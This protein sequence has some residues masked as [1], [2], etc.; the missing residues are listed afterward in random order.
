M[1]DKE[2]REKIQRSMDRSLSGLPR[3]SFLTER[4]LNKAQ[5]EEGEKKVIK[6]QTGRLVLAVVLIVA[7]ATAAL[8]LGN[9]ETLKTYFE[10]VRGMESTGELARWSAEDKI[11]LARAM[12]EAGIVTED[13][14]RLQAALDEDKPLSQRG[15]AAD[16]LISQ[17][18]G[19]DYF[20]SYT[21][22]QLELLQAGLSPTDQTAYGQWSEDY[23]ARWSQKEKQPLTE[24]R[25]YL[26]TMNNLTE[27]GDFPRE[28][29]REVKVSGAWEEGEGLYAVT[30][31]IDKQTYRAAQRPGSLSLFDTHALEPEEGDT[32]SFRFWLDE[33]GAF[34]G[35]YDPNAPENRA[36]IT[37]R[38]AQV[39]AEKALSVRLGV[40][41]KTRQALPLRSSCGEGNEYVLEEG[42]FRAVCAF[43]WGE[44]EDP[45]YFVDIDAQTGRVI[46]A[47][48]WRE[49]QTM[50]EKEKAWL[51][52]IRALLRQAGVSDTLYNQEQVYFWRW[53]LEQKA[54]WSKTARPLIERYLAEHDEFTGYLEDLLAKRYSQSN[55]PNLI[56]LTQYAYGIPGEDAL[57]QEKAFEIAREAALQAGA[58][59]S[60]V[61]DSEGHNFYYD[62][63]DP[64]QPLWKVLVSTM[65]PADDPAHP[66]DPK[67][68]WGYFAVID[69]TTGELLKLQ[70]R[71]VNTPMRELV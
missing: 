24:S 59:Q 13:D 57:T 26:A 63:T 55:W 58:K 2:L 34:L 27:V 20:D 44:E 4:V 9:W 14:A 33:Y 41:E 42:R 35:I 61:D 47:F 25:I 3:D 16:A 15:E 56:A 8:A 36:E 18:Y 10:A 29:L 21:L 60:D 23:W 53:P 65:F 64:N 31:S 30:A 68:P 6:K 48:D 11:K 69:A 66:Y 22:E 67:A 19:P 32:L 62:V 7:L 51:D 1:R 40:D 45:R 54:A 50:K 43:I 46:Q 39:I 12:A 52:E 5:E 38:E 17:R 37:L 49:S 28:L 70:I 71:T